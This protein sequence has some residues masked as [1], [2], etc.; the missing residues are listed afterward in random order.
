MQIKNVRYITEI[1]SDGKFKF[2][3]QRFEVKSLSLKI[4]LIIMQDFSHTLYV[5]IIQVFLAVHTLVCQKKVISLG[6]QYLRIP[7]FFSND[8]GVDRFE[9]FF[10][11]RFPV[12]LGTLFSIWAFFNIS[13]GQT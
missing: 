9:T 6:D 2:G 8:D 4:K 1:L 5:L 7:I 11:D 12:S 10:F 13:F 3:A